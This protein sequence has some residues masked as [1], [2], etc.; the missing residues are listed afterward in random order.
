M[1]TVKIARAT[2]EVRAQIYNEK[3]KIAQNCNAQRLEGDCGEAWPE[4]P[5]LLREPW[6]LGEF[7]VP[8]KG[9]RRVIPLR[10]TG[11]EI[12]IQGNHVHV[13]AGGG[14]A[15]DEVNGGVHTAKDKLHFPL[16]M[17]RHN[18][19]Q[20]VDRL[21]GGDEAEG[22]QI[23]EGQQIAPTRPQPLMLM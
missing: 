15:M 5:A 17:G 3:S 20:G 19:Q 22:P 6:S 21:R 16:P 8:I 2:H 11:R 13:A 7:G 12:I 10:I 14:R 4:L 18:T 9:E 1:Y 23:G